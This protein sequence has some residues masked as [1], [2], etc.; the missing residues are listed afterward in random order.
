M[1]A[2]EETEAEN[3]IPEEE[4]EVTAAQ[5]SIIYAEEADVLN[6]AMFG[7]TAKQWREVHPELCNMGTVLLLYSP[8]WLW[9]QTGI[10]FRLLTLF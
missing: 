9:A 5:A 4:E 1:I 8:K 7:Q 2:K 3:L 10:I 6:V